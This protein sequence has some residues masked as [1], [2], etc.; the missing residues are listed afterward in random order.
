MLAAGRS[1]VLLLVGRFLQGVSA[2]VVWTVGL[3]LLSDTIEKEYIGQA[4]GY[5]AAA[6]SIGSLLGPLLGGVLYEFAGY[7]SVFALGFAI[8]GL[9]IFLR[10]VMIEKVVAR[11]WDVSP[12]NTSTSSGN[13][14]SNN[15]I[16][17]A[18]RDP[19]EKALPG[20][21][22]L[23]PVPA[24]PKTWSQRLPPVVTL[25]CIP[26]LLAALLGCFVQSNS[27]GSFDSVLPL[28]VK[29]T[30]HWN[31]TGAGLIFICLVIPALLGPIIGMASDKF[32]CRALTTVGLLISVP[33]WV[34]L[35][36]VTENS[37]GHKVLLCAILAIIGL[38]TTMV[39]APLMAEI[40]HC[41][42]EREMRRPGSLGKRGAA[43]QGYGLFNLAY[44]VGSLVGPLWAGFIVSS[45]GFSTMVWTIGL[46]SGVS[47]VP[48]FIYTGG[49]IMLKGKEGS[50]GAGGV[51]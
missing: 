36:F 25:L 48:I 51:V 39:M 16:Q 6:T 47:A 12:D 33:A 21:N 34:C 23:H 43:A 15:E 42:T 49:R 50:V 18:A 4:M 44:A 32:G 3:A 9:D 29:D 46:L 45:V 24:G 38:C 7:Y 8:I 31:S 11:Q 26:R 41:L 13:I 20:E 5:I 28:F 19:N 17:Q 30:F 27:L 1:L 35:R 2:A 10:L 40:D 37:I 14:E 22:T